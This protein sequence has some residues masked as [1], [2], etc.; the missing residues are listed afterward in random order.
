MSKVT[1]LAQMVSLLPRNEFQKLALEHES[2]KHTKGIDAWTHLISM[3]FCHLSN[4]A[5]VR[6]ISNGLRS[7]TG[8]IN[9]LGCVRAPS[10][11]TISYINAHR[12]HR[13]FEAFFYKV[14]DRLGQQTG[15]HV[16]RLKGLSK[17]VLLL[18]STTIPLCQ[19]VFDWARFRRHKGAIKLHMVLDYQGCIPRYACIS[20]GRDHDAKVA[21]SM[22]FPPGSVVVADR[23]YC[24][25]RWL[26]DLDSRN[27]DFVLRAKENLRF[28]VVDP[29]EPVQAQI[30][31]DDKIQLTGSQSRKKYPKPLRRVEFYDEEQDRTLVFLTNNM[32]W[33]AA[34]VA[35]LYKERW[36]IEVFF[37][38]IK[39]HLRIKSF[40]GTTA[41]AVKIQ[42]WTALIAILLLKALQAMAQ[43]KWHLSNM[44]AFIRLNLFVKIQL[45]EYLDRP[46][47][48]ESPP[49]NDQISLSLN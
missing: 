46:F 30:I 10:K 23:A 45:K 47:T 2:N 21:K 7:C 40:V 32:D 31:W 4:A 49:E 19:K 33:D 37:K 9:H 13:L 1:L 44:V 29:F 3:L 8:N 24:D 12:D 6:D 28:D 18:D 34:T 14:L 5:S 22:Q 20:E 15:F 43:Y 17:Q 25:F 35:Q 11:S 16:Q 36:N 27:V 38:H 26:R 42:I 48:S 39:S 41:N